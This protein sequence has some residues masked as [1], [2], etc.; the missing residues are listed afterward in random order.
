VEILQLPWLRRCPL[1]NTPHRN[2][3]QPAWGPRCI[4]SGRT[5]QKTPPPTFPLLFLLAVPQQELEYCW[6]VYRPL[7]SNARSFS[8]SFHSNGTTRYNKILYVHIFK[9]FSFPG[10]Y[11]LDHPVFIV[12]ISQQWFFYRARSSTLCPTPQSGG[13]GPYI[14]VPQWQRGP[15]IPPGTGFPFRHLLR[16]AGRRWRYSNPPP[17]GNKKILV[18]LIFI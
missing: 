8:R 4:T 7:P 6:R 14:Y 16:L 3:P 13:P 12:W 11:E 9:S 10:C 5:Q 18:N 1:V 2:C 17:R 15:V